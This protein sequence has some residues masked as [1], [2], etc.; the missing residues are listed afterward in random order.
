MRTMNRADY[1]GVLRRMNPLMVLV[2]LT[3]AVI[4]V[5]FVYSAC[6]TA[7]D[8]FSGRPMRQLQW[9]VFGMFLFF[10]VAIADYHKMC[11]D[12][13]WIYALSVILLVLVLVAGKK[14]YGARR[15]LELP[16]FQFQP[17]E[18]AKLATVLFLARFMTRQ[19]VDFGRFGHVAAIL[20]IAA[21]PSLL[22]FM[23]PDL[24]SALVLLPVVLAMMF[25]ARVPA[26]YMA[27]IVL[28]GVI[29][30][31][32]VLAV[33][34]VPAKLGYDKETQI[35]VM[36][37]VGIKSYHRDRIETF[38]DPAKDP[39]GAGYNKMQSE[40]AIGSGGWS[41][42]GYRK[43]V[44]TFLAFLPRTVAP[45][46]FIFAVV[47]EEKGFMGAMGILGLYV[48]VIACGL[49][50]AV[51]AAD[52]MGRLLCVGMTTIVFVHVFVNI[53]MTVGVLPVTGIPLP[54]MSCGGTF[55][56]C[57]LVALGVIQSVH[58][59]RRFLRS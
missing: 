55:A 16:G 31:G 10:A 50:A 45:T 24:G 36:K 22:I 43:S 51:V 39:L 57:T 1:T 27:G 9:L 34:F 12:A 33:M 23:Q 59:R 4:G 18:V 21:V 54:L 6:M 48:T 44:S 53:G 37:M 47:A 38:L 46:D 11:R 40:N 25:V 2:I 49:W 26:R 3:L 7:G 29:A 15:W 19:Y 32:M 30:A 42:R 28:V 58:A 52:K 17:S 8:Q 5:L 35:K 13:W 20:A 14:V 41:G 56:V